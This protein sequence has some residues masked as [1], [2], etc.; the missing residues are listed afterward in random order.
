MDRGVDGGF[1]ILEASLL[2]PVLPPIS[3]LPPM[4]RRRFLQCAAVSAAA[5]T[6]DAGVLGACTGRDRSSSPKTA[7]G[8]VRS[9]RSPSAVLGGLGA[10]LYTVRGLMDEDVGETLAA[11]ADAGYETVETAGLHGLSPKA[12]AEQLQRHDLHSPAGHYGLDA[13]QSEPQRII[14]TAKTLGQQYVVV[15][16]LAEAHRQSLDDYRAAA[17]TFNQLGERCREAGLRFGYHNHDFEFETF[18][19]ER[20]AYDVL[21]E[22]TDPVLVVM[23]A[24]VYWMYKAGYDPVAYFEQYPGRFELAHL[25]DGTAPPE[26]AMVDVGRG[27]LDF[28]KLLALGERAGLRFAFV[29]HDRPDDALASLQ[30]S[31]DHLSGLQP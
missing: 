11:V 16:W 27:T 22:R 7:S 9:G 23:E 28:E 29:E 19:G 4:N 17:D 26:K 25:K 18:G 14:D 30:A 21:M 15:P 13:L 24:D 31:Y 1:A 8:N 6:L 2:C 12:F 3:N 5:G 10:Q 20:P